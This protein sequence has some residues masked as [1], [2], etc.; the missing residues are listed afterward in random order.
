[1]AFPFHNGWFL[2]V[3]ATIA[4]VLCPAFVR[5]DDFHLTPSLSLKQEYNDNILFTAT[6]EQDDLI[7]T[8]TPGLYVRERTERL[9]L[10]LNSELDAVGYWDH[11]ELNAFDTRQKAKAS[12]RLT[13]LLGISAGA[14]YKEDSRSD[15]DLLTTGQILRHSKR[16][17][18]D[19]SAGFDWTFS[20]TGRAGVTAFYGRRDY[21]YSRY[22]D[23]TYDGFSADAVMDIGQYLPRARGRAN[24]TYVRYD[25]TTTVSRDYLATVGLEYDVSERLTVKGDI[26]PR[27]TDSDYYGQND[28]NWGVGGSLGLDFAYDELTTFSIKVSEET[29][30]RSGYAGTVDQTKVDGSVKRR[31]PGDW[32]LG[33]EANYRK[34]KSQNDVPLYNTDEDYYSVSPRLTYHLTDDVSVQTVYRYTT[35]KERLNRSGKRVSRRNLLFARLQYRW[36]LFD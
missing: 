34:N 5:A 17:S 14:E 1:M 13:E 22:V 30:D 35:L 23:S 32:E 7:T 28:T 11:D 18:Q 12:Y 8:L 33:L 36:P 4:A 19:Y 9:E 10:S 3:S 16:Y 26:G 25:Y 6:G 2:A 24:F 21:D 20:E 27:Y 29:A 31:L 15:R